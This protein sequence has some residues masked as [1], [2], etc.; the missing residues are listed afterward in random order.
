MANI[1]HEIK[2]DALK[3]VVWYGQNVV[4]KYTSIVKVI[5]SQIGAEYATI[6]SQ[7]Q[8]SDSA[9]KGLSIARWLSDKFSAKAVIITEL[10]PDTYTQ[11]QKILQHKISRISDFANKLLI[12]EKDENVKW[13]QLILKSII[14]PDQSYV[15]YE[16]GDVV[17]SAW[18]FEFI[19][20]SMAITGYSKEIKKEKLIQAQPPIEEVTEEEKVTEAEVINNTTEG[21]P[22]EGDDKKEVVVPQSDESSE[23]DP[24]SEDII[25]EEKVV[26]K[27]KSWLRKYWWLLLLLLLLPL[28]YFLIDYVKPIGPDGI[29][30]KVPSIGEVIPP[31]DLDD[32]IKSPDSLTNIVADRLNIALHGDNKDL[33]AFCKE[34]KKIYPDDT[35][36]IVYQDPKTARIQIQIP[37]EQLQTI[38]GELSSKMSGYNLLIWHESL[39]KK[40]T[41]FSD[42]GFSEIDKSWYFDEVQAKDAWDITQGDNDIIIAVLDSGFDLEHPELEG[43]IYKPWDV[44]TGS[45]SIPFH[46]EYS[47]HGTHVASISGA[48]SNNGE[49]VSGIAPNCKIMPV[50]VGDKNGTLASSYVVDGFLYA[51]N[52]GADVINMS[53]G[54]YVHPLIETLPEQAQKEIIDNSFKDEEQFWQ[55]IFDIALKNKTAVVLAGG[56]QN[57]LIGIDPLDRSAYP[58][59][60]SATNRASTKADFSNWGDYSDVSAPGDNIYSAIGNRDYD[61]L[62]GTSMAAPIVAG[63]VGLIKSVKKELTASEIKYVL[64]ATGKYAYA[65]NNKRIGNVIQIKD[66]L[67]YLETGKLPEINC[68]DIQSRIDS[69]TNEIEKLKQQCGLTE[70]IDT[71]QFPSTPTKNPNFANGRWKST[72]PLTSSLSNDKVELY[73]DVNNQNE[74][75]LTL[76]EEDGTL[77]HADLDISISSSE[78]QFVQKEEAR[79]DNSSYYEKYV[80]SCKADANGTAICIAKNKTTNRQDVEFLL[81]RV[82]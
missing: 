22:L 72:S 60:V 81:I 4:D 61:Y 54:L 28:I 15:L 56:N 63:A 25:E 73:F 49:G 18:G 38:K 32:V 11:A 62:S 39:F 64:K 20:P 58:I 12:S 8:I 44:T 46:S 27:K 16:N 65:P 42:P 50:K 35:F 5:S 1:I 24:I 66:A 82:R 43:Q 69:L 70:T 71:L 36:K 14:Y 13:G 59:R 53:L 33:D 26:N 17:I 41:T 29:K 51:I 57:V 2:I 74:G 78:L 30:P 47:I 6:F 77:C 21:A 7:P 3:P 75:H 76:V 31:V 23:K 55:Q 45:S 48:N 19:D 67:E 40:N 37:K 79:C 10:D 68:S 52:H 9:F 80:F 34:L